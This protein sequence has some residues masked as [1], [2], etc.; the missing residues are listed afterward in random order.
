MVLLK[1]RH[2]GRGYNT[3][4]ASMI[5]GM[6]SLVRFRSPDTPDSDFAIL[7]R[8]VALWKEEERDDVC[9]GEVAATKVFL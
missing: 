2:L 7:H 5:F 8:S 9:F 6:T 3:F 4:T 1:S